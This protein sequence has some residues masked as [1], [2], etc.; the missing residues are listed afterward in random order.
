MN[1]LILGSAGQIGSALCQYIKE[2]GHTVIEFD[3]ASDYKHD[4]RSGT[5]ALE[6]AMSNAHFVF[7]LAFDVGGSTYLKTYQHT[8]EFINNN[9]R[10]MN[11]VF[12]ALKFYKTPFIFASSQM[13]NMAFSPYGTLKSIGEFYTKTLNGIVVKFWNVY[14]I[15]NDPAKTHVITDFVDMAL[16]TRLI[17]MKTDGQE[18]RQFL[19]AEDCCEALYLLANTYTQTSRD[20]SLHITSF[21]WIKILDIAK[22]ISKLC[23]AT[24][25]EGNIKD[26]VQQGLRNEP[27]PYILSLWKPQTSIEDGIQKIVNQHKKWLRRKTS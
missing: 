6:V 1:F 7:F 15:E 5:N 17:R 26:T 11:T 19:Y 20:H 14:G 21:K 25:L 16:N 12:D 9:S 27:D 18:E 4:L 23:D 10:I 8:Y 24:I 2:R 3:I 13:S 22:I